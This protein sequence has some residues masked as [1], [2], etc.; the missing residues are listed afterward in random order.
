[1][2]SRRSRRSSKRRGS[3]R[4]TRALSKRGSVLTYNKLLSRLSRGKNRKLKAWVCVGPKRTG[5]GGGKK[6][7]RGS[8]VM[9]ILRP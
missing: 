4:G 8:R 5:C 9:G 6:G 1:M 2:S 3:K 7:R